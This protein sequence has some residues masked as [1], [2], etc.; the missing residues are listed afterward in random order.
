MWAHESHVTDINTSRHM[1]KSRHTSQHTNTSCHANERVTSF[2]ATFTKKKAFGTHLQT[3]HVPH[4]IESCPTHNWVMSHRRN[5]AS[6][7]I[8]T[9]LRHCA[10]TDAITTRLHEQV[11][12]GTRTNESWHTCKW[13]I[14]HL[15]SI[16]DDDSI[17]V[18]RLHRHA[19]VCVCVWE[20]ESVCAFVCVS[21]RVFACECIDCRSVW[22]WSVHWWVENNPLYGQLHIWICA[23]ES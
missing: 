8:H 20:R 6:C 23:L 13:D 17:R 18:T 16:G 14:S 5:N 22:I 19:S 21:V 3:S 15:Q 9:Q 1:N 11:S 7:R 2:P 4:T 12:H 10:Y